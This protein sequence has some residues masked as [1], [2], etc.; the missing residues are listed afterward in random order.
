MRRVRSADPVARIITPV[1]TV[2]RLH[3]SLHPNAAPESAPF[4]IERFNHLTDITIVWNLHT[5]MLQACPLSVFEH[6]G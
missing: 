5:D 1:H 6:S 4:Q 3:I 2:P